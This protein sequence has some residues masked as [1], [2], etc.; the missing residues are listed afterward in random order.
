MHIAGLCQ[1]PVDYVDPFIGTHDAR[2]M[3]FAGATMPF[4]MVKLSPDNKKSGWK[5]GH[6]YNI[7]NIAGFN[8][9]HD[10]HVT[11]FY[12][13]P[14][15]G[16]IQTQPGTED[17]PDLGYRSRISQQSEHA[18]PG[19]YSVLLKDYGIKAEL[20]ATMR[21]G[22]QRYTF[23]ESNEASIM[24]D[25]EIPYEDPGNVL[26]VKVNK[27]SNTEITG[28]VKI[29]DE[30]AMGNTIWLHNDYYLYFVT[31][32]DKPFISL[33]GW[34]A[35][36]LYENIAS[37]KGEGDVGCYLRY[38]TKKGEQIN[39]HTALSMVSIEQARLNLDTETKA[40]GFDFEKYKS[41][42]RE[43]WNKLLGKISI[44][45]KNEKNKV[46]FYTN[47]YR[48]YSAK[49]TWSDVNGK[50]VDMNEDVVQ[51]PKNQP[52]YGSDAFWG[53]KWNLNGLWSLV[54]PS[55]MNTWIGSMLE[56][57][58]RGGWLPKGP[59]AGE[60]T[61]I[62]TGSPAVEGIVAAYEQGIRGYNIELAY[63]AIYKIMM[64][65]GK[66]HKSGG[67][68]GNRWLQQYMDY[69]YVPNEDGP[70]SNTMELAFQDWCVAQMAKSLGK[71]KDY[72][73][74]LKRSENYKNHLDTAT[75]YARIRSAAG[76][77]ITPFN[78]FSGEGFIEG[79]AWQYTFY[80]PH[81]VKGI[82][83]FLGKDQF[84][85]RLETGFEQSKISKFNATGD[86]YAKYP[87]N[88]GNQPNMEAAFLF[89][90]AGEP[91]LT[92]K[93][94][95]ELLDVYYGDTPMDGWPGDEDQG[96]M[97]AWFVM[98]SLGLFQ[99]QGGC[100]TQPIFDLGSPLF[101]EAI[102]KLENGKSLK[103]IANNNSDKNIYV[104]S[105][106]LNGKSLKRA[107]V[108]YTEIS[109]GGKL[110]FEMGP[111]PNKS[112]GISE[113]PPSMSAPGKW[114]YDPVELYI[115]GKNLDNEKKKTFMD[116]VSVSMKTNAVNGMIRFTTDGSKPTQKSAEYNHPLTFQKTVTV[117]SA[118]FN[119]QGKQVSPLRRASFIKLDFEDNLT[120]GQTTTA[121]SFNKENEPK[122][123]VDGFVDRDHFWDASPAPQWWMVEL[124]EPKKISKLELF[125]Y[126]D[127]GRY[128]QYTIEASLDGKNWTRVVDAS[129]NKKMATK[130]GY[131]HTIAPMVAK[132][133]RVNM[134][135]NSANA[136]VHISEFRVHE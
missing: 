109:K 41:D 62:M 10:Y 89:N 65:Q 99:M 120:I 85:N 28:Y 123:A 27:I 127:G 42:G 77:W 3:I 21:M 46:K 82:I 39:V 9:I 80:A 49:S 37:L 24:F 90:Y 56:I 68:V 20:S 44:T 38:K 93:W 67:W 100:G 101:K 84:L 76:N 132:W 57:Y 17:N 22:I 86:Q 25:F 136:G 51:A 7:K 119:D 133:F 121:S 126:W 40:Y 54:N 52:V 47:L 64:E 114:A 5:G 88:H 58:K 14:T 128:Y 83:N 104:Q 73:Y 26:E 134:I 45:D 6:E 16:K 53:M 32:V 55:L 69:G 35:D 116:T 131:I 50:W 15:V 12:V 112:W 70:A 81:D 92:Q 1:Q 18:T 111:N 33:G 115:L 102:V 43:V 118:V 97:G 91:W 48:C 34:K 94:E 31:K 107:W 125:T 30:Q 105:V 122:Y 13:M 95:R 129:D 79:N 63:E 23:P 78:P 130:N 59:T 2:P 117:T 113:L 103:V 96:Q 19:Y 8:F 71:E 75:A 36:S 106:Y 29:L 110:E 60:Y 74:F 135:K 108:Y 61:G 4:G 124:K 72:E 11:G 98:G 87:I 66:V